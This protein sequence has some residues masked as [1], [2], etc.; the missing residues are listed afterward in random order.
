MMISGRPQGG[1]F[2]FGRRP[3]KYIHAAKSFP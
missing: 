3:E 1:R 2:H